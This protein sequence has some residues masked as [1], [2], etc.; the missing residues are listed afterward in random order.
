MFEV[1]VRGSSFTVT[2]SQDIKISSRVLEAVDEERNI[3]FVKD[4][5]DR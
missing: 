5:G 3:S 1:I 4:I 2:K